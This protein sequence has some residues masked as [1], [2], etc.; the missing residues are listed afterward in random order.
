VFG[1]T[2]EE[3]GFTSGNGKVTVSMDALVAAYDMQAKFLAGEVSNVAQTNYWFTIDRVNDYDRYFNLAIINYKYEIPPKAAIEFVNAN[4]EIVEKGQN[5]QLAVESDYE[6]NEI[7]WSTSD[8][9]VAIVENGVVT[10][11][12]GG[13]VTITASVD[14]FAISK[15]VYVAS[16][17]LTGNE[18]NK[19]S[20]GWN[21]AGLSMTAIENGYSFAVKFSTGAAGDGYWITLT[22]PR[23]YYEKL[24]EEGYALTF[25]LSVTG[26][27]GD[28]YYGEFNWP[29]IKVFGKTLEEYGFTS[30]NGK[31]TVSMDALIAA[32][33]MQA[34]FL[35]GQ[36]S[37]VA[38]TNY[39]FTIDRVDDYDRYFNIAITNY[40]F[41]KVEG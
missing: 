16:A 14:G 37:N 9:T 21:N 39:W 18:L 40:T 5:L 10:G 31:V 34:Q 19:V 15:K 30:G 33:D 27:E 11:V 29:L 1:K 22:Q 4:D 13:A 20:W 26:H 32:Y 6:A 25:D 24:A 41:V 28:A 23:S 2:L 8:S 3:Y 17:E 7:I 38:Q 35:G 36:V 12:N